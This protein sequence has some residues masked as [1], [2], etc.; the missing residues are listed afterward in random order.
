[1]LGV[2]EAGKTLR[3]W[4]VSPLV[5]IAAY[6]FSWLWILL[7][8]A[9][10][11][12][13]HPTD[14]LMLWVF[15]MTVSFV[16]RHF[17][18]PYV[19]LDHQVFKTHVGRFTLVPVALFA[20][21]L[22]TPA[23]SKWT[24]KPNYFTPMDAVV[25]V[26]FAVVAFQWWWQDKRIPRW[27]WWALAIASAPFIFALGLGWSGVPA[28]HT[29]QALL[30]LGVLTAVSGVLAT[31][32]AKHS[33]GAGKK[34]YAFTV[35]CALLLIG[36]AAAIPAGGAIGQ[37]P[38]QKLKFKLVIGGIAT[39]AAAWNIWHVYMQKFGILRMY[40]AKSDA[41]VEAK[42]PP[43][44]DRLFLFGWVPL[45]FVGLA[46]TAKDLIKAQAP[47]VAVY[48]VPITDAMIAIRPWALGPAIALVGAGFLTFGWWEWKST[49][50][51]NW[52]RLSMAAGTALLAAS[53]FVVNPLKVYI[54]FGF[55]HAVE[56]MV[57]VWA[58]QRK[59]YAQPLPHRPLLGRLLNWPV[60]SYG[61]F[62]LIVGGVGFY[63]DFADDVGLIVG[64][65]QIFGTRAS[66][67]LFYWTIWHSMAHFYFDGFLWKMRLPEVRAN[68]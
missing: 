29:T 26:G 46:P 42:V 31:D 32:V 40:N 13:R 25:A 65:L 12:D 1:M 18:M 53:F 57:F 43:W 27:S 11:G 4:H 61:I 10:V 35:L 63:L 45:Y 28:G 52:A 8:L 9:M 14:Y 44:V 67:W 51:T 36:A 66:S 58:F 48:V 5:D 56:Y 33:E 59:R 50:F 62:L 37:W 22:A 49:K 41:A 38:D 17:T 19:Y 2:P 30:A 23:L 54:A 64:K 21:F 55:S 15:G 6:H 7:P 47:S 34:G 3:Q 24:V 39:F 60:L 68:I 20:A 16:H